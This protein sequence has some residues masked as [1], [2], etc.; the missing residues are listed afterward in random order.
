MRRTFCVDAFVRVD[1][2]ALSAVERGERKKR[3]R[4]TSAGGVLPRF[5]WDRDGN[6][7][8]V[9]AF[10]LKDAGVDLSLSGS[11]VLVI[12]ACCTDAGRRGEGIPMCKCRGEITICPVWPTGRGRRWE[13]LDCWHCWDFSRG[14]G[15]EVGINYG[16]EGGSARLGCRV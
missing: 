1:A 16:T 6:V 11:A 4:R 14:G 10:E 5:R 8:V 7:P 2:A 12:C 15:E 9:V 3:E 13:D